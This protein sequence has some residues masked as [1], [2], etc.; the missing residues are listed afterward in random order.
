MSSAQEIVRP[1]RGAAEARYRTIRLAALHAAEALAASAFTMPVRLTGI[2]PEALDIAH[3]DWAVHP[4]RRCQWPW[5]KMIADFRR[6]E[7]ARFEVAIWT[8]DI[9]CGLAIGRTRADHCRMD[10]LEA[11]PTPHPLKGRIVPI[12]A[13]AAIAYA[14]ALGKK[15]LRLVDPLPEVVHL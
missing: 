14:T 11:S 10:Y 1:S 3:Y 4:N 5:R 8:D 15:E 6:A 7:P 12:A 2:G 9:L 13:G